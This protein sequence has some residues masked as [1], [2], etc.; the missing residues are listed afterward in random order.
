M[1]N[2]TKLVAFKAFGNDL[3]ALINDVILPVG[4]ARLRGQLTMPKLISTNA[5]D[6]ARQVGES[7]RVPK[8]VE[9]DSADEHGSEGSQASNISVEKVDLEL[10]RHIYKEFKMSDR[11]FTGSR[12]G[13][14]PD[15]A[16]AAIDVLART[17]NT[18]IFD[19]AKEVPNFAGNLNSTNAR[20]KSDLIT[21]RK[22]MHNAKLLGDKTLVLTSDTEADLLGI[23]TAG[24]DQN[25]ETEG[26]I[27]RR[28]GFNVYS[29][30]QA[31]YH[32]A[33][34]AS[35]DDGITL[36]VS[37]AAGAKTLVIEGAT[38]GAT[39]VKGDIVTV[40]GSTQ[41]FAVAQDVVAEDGT[42]VVQVTEA[43]R[44]AIESGSAVTVVGSHAVDL[45]FQKSA[46]MIAFRQL[47]TAEV[48]DGTTI[49]SI[50][51]PE[52]GVTLRL[53][54]W[55]DPRT[56]STHWKFETLFGVK[57]VAPERAIRLGGH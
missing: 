53:L 24:N 47:E 46:F 14:I 17:I 34:S 33:G 21:A 44:T 51:D 26:M 39:L 5:G 43:V 9:F 50:T 28:F 15:A 12:P 2:V 42:A 8:P 11:E 55:Y 54:R 27:G 36:S 6:E 57:A 20:D 49:G 18:A 13:V 56:E 4:L 3:E 30:I 48:T 29:D 22:V 32:E 25:A 16:A 1:T 31:P 23:F 45:A 38:A 35:S 40:A 10:N 41:S 19:L 7:I 37:A 52:T